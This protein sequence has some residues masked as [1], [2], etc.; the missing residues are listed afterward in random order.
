[1]KARLIAPAVGLFCIVI[2]PVYV[3]AATPS[4]NGGAPLV[5]A[6]AP[7][8]ACGK[9]P[10][11]AGTTWDGETD[12]NGIKEKETYEFKNGGKLFNTT[13]NGRFGD[14]DWKQDG[15]C[16]YMNLGPTRGVKFEGKVTGDRLEGTFKDGEMSWTT[17][18]RRRGASSSASSGGGGGRWEGLRSDYKRQYALG[19]FGEAAKLA[20]RAAQ[21]AEKEFGPASPNLIESLNELALIYQMDHKFGPALPVAQRALAAS[22]KASGRESKEY[23]NALNTVGKSYTGLKKYVEAED[24]YKEG[25]ATSEK[26]LG[27]KDQQVALLL[28]NL[29][30][31][32]SEQDRYAEAEPYLERSLQLIEKG[33]AGD[34]AL[35]PALNN[36]AVAKKELQKYDEALMLYERSLGIMERLGGENHPLVGRV[37]ENLAALYDRKG[38]KEEAQEA[39][40]RALR[41]RAR[42]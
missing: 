7:A 8:Q 22:E 11:L 20:E 38:W 23:A 39:R 5:Q 32:Y 33:S 16:V 29:G 13:A 37:L 2:L 35:A 19:R 21:A 6:A 14:N 40:E 10:S 17:V 24:A 26:L 4:W 41:I 31:L 25:L 12:Y 9:A 18:A 3:L 27:P 30:N 28:N 34:N 36:L 42:R 15:D 1:M